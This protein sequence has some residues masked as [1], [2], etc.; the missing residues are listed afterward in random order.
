MVVGG[1]ALLGVSLVVG[2]RRGCKPCNRTAATTLPKSV[3]PVIQSKELY[4]VRSLAF[5]CG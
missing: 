3:R 2:W 1:V 5:G 4:K